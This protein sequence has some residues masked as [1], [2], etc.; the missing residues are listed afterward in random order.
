LLHCAVGNWIFSHFGSCLAAFASVADADCI[1]QIARVSASWLSRNF[2]RIFAC[3][4]AGV[5]GCGPLGGCFGH[6]MTFASSQSYNADITICGLLGIMHM[7]LFAASVFH[8]FHALSVCYCVLTI[9]IH[10]SVCVCVCACEYLCVHVACKFIVYFCR[11]VAA[12]QTSSSYSP[13][14]P[15]YKC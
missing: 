7:S 3:E 15:L 14:T 12:C 9:S 6:I 5:C 2:Y 8:S 4:C 1:L 11:Q 10:K 13:N